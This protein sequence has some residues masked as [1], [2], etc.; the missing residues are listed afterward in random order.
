MVI[1]DCLTY[2]F[3]DATNGIDYTLRDNGDGL[4][5]YIDQWN[6][7]NTQ[8]TTAQLEAAWVVISTANAWNLVRD[9]R[10]AMLL[11]ADIEIFKA[12][13]NAGNLTP[14]RV[15][16]QALRDI[17]KGPDANNPAWPTKPW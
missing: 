15:Y 4:G 3:P 14:L 7:T 11:E 10:V 13:D 1:S 8:P 6:L 2:L 16:R 9:Q 12:E 17:T 5:V